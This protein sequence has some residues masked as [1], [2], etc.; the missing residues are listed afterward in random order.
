MARPTLAQVYLPGP[1]R[2]LMAGTLPD[3]PTVVVR[4]GANWA[5]GLEAEWDALLARCP[6]A[7]PFQ[8]RA[9]VTTWWE[10]FSRGRESHVI[11]A[12][13][14]G[15]LT[16]LFPLVRCRGPWS[17]LRPMGVGPSDYLAPLGAIDIKVH[18]SLV[19]LHQ[20]PYAAAEASIEQ[21]T[22]LQVDLPTSFD[23]YLGRLSKSLRYDVRRM[24]KI[25]DLEFCR[26]LDPCDS[27]DILFDLHQRRWKARGLPGAFVGRIKRFHRDWLL[28]CGDMA[29]VTVL[30]W[31][32]KPVGAIYTMHLHGATY[33]YQAGFDPEAS[34]ISPGTL[35]VGQA[36]REAIERGDHR[37]DFCRGDEPYKRRWKPDRVVVNYRLMDAHSSLGRLGLSWN[38]F[39]WRIEATLRQRLEGGTLF[40]PRPKSARSELA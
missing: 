13:E 14:D 2:P 8:S 9:W 30:K 38:R 23:A 29:K 19:D 37:F 17:A 22:C 12:R 6:E 25:A 7:T 20:A 18:A 28:R 1:R 34:A 33:F 26:D 11:E 31:R 15:V 3:V 24:D 39:A 40:P 4:T 21:A 35:L 10:H 36:I 16:G 32:G 27:L 5:D